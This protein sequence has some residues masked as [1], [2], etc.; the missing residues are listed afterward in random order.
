MIEYTA[1]DLGMY[2]K[3]IKDNPAW[4]RI[5]DDVLVGLTKQWVAAQTV[6]DREDCW[7]RYHSLKEVLRGIDATITNGN[8]A[9]DDED[10]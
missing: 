9:K 3:E 10:H 1:I 7:Y 6:E 4:N 5:I 2:A 8:F